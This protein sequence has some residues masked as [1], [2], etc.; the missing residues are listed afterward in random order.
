[1]WM[2]RRRTHSRWF[3]IFALATIAPQARAEDAFY[4]MPLAD[5]KLTEG[6]LSDA[7]GGVE[8]K[9]PTFDVRYAM[10]P[11]VVL[12]G[13]GE[14]YIEQ[15][16]RYVPQL[17]RLEGALVASAPTGRDLTG[18]L[19]LPKDH[20]SGMVKLRFVIPSSAGGKN[21]DRFNRAKMEHYESLLGGDIPGTAWFRHQYRAAQAELGKPRSDDV[22]PTSWD[23]A[24]GIEETFD[25]FS[26]GRAVRENLYL[27]RDLLVVG[28]NDEPVDVSSLEGITIAEIDWKPLLAEARPKADPLA[29]IIPADQH[30]VF[31]PSFAAAV[32]VADEVARQGTPLSRVMLARSEDELIKQRYERQLC[33]PLS[34]L[35]R[36]LGPTVIGSVA[37]TGS[38]PYFFTGTD[39][40][41]VFESEHPAA[42]KA[43]LLGRAAAAAGEERAKPASGEAA[44][45][46][47]SGFTSP[48]RRVSCHI[49]SL[50]GAVVVTNSLKQLERLAAVTNGAS[51]A[52]ATLDE[53]KFFRQ[54]YSH[55]DDDETALLFLS[56]ATIRRWCSPRWR[57][58]ASRRL[59]SAAVVS[60]LQARFLDDL[61]RGQVE[62]GPIHSD[63]P[64][65]GGGQLRLDEHGV[66]STTD[67]S[68]EFQTPIIE[69]SIDQVTKAEADAYNRWRRLYQSNWRWA[70]DPIAL[71]LTVTDERLAADLTVMPLIFGSDY[72]ELVELARGSEIA[73]TSGDPHPSLAQFVLALNH[74][75]RTMRDGANLA[76]GVLR[77]DPL[78]WLGE[79]VS[80][81]LDDDPEYF[82]ELA[83]QDG[84]EKASSYLLARLDRL[85]LGMHVAVGDPW[86]LT[87]VL[88]TLRALI[89]QTAPKMTVWESLDYR[90]EPYVRVGPSK[91][92]EGELPREFGRPSLYYSFSAE[93]LL[94]T[95]NEGLL[96]RAIDRQ[97]VR[98]QVKK[99]GKP[100]PV[101]DRPWLGTSLCFQFDRRLLKLFDLFSADELRQTLQSRSWANLPVLNEWR[102]RYPDRDPVQVHEAFWQTRPVCPGGGE[103]VWN[104]E[105]QTMESTVYGHPGEPK[106]GPISNLPLSDLI[107]GNFG[108]TFEKQG[109]R[110]KAVLDR[111]AKHTVRFG[112]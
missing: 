91:R 29:R 97:L 23:R 35:A 25:L 82:K 98:R 18:S 11:R 73:P 39:V 13:Q 43:L 36:L 22:W 90:D 112:H 110:A 64:L 63:L 79:W 104:E 2:N 40:A 7:E 100:L 53:Y 27:D 54:R 109:L 72:R 14:A 56:D 31:F 12:D 10:Q 81:Y 80:V 1:M 67:G 68:L 33:L 16:D 47:W 103:Y 75:S 86:K 96:K 102:G 46:A 30:A 24:A 69:L 38:D 105:W 111:D 70:F 101:G 76:A 71:R 17:L 87:T 50:D 106:P 51:P 19:Y 107:G 55:G 3:V 62:A 28:K 52:L 42:L 88:T 20:Y 5:L 21:G 6:K 26:G 84:A 60:E 15:S 65:P 57:I 93:G 41:V 44:G 92:A 8:K 58:A 45:I 95:F 83:Q 78:N 89:E 85:P 61:V 37:I 59:R 74:K 9:R 32:A 49:A 34:A 108:L 77:V 4:R 99:E 94:V 48:D 66:Q